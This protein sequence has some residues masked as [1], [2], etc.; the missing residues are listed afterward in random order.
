MHK[1]SIVQKIDIS[2]KVRKS[3]QN[4]FYFFTFNPPYRLHLCK[5]IK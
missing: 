4:C 1:F 5:K 3:C 2:Q